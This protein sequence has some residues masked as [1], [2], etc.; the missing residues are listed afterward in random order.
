MRNEYRITRGR[1][2]RLIVKPC[3]GPEKT[4]WR[5]GVL[6]AFLAFVFGVGNVIPVS[7]ALSAMTGVSESLFEE[8]VAQPTQ[9]VVVELTLPEQPNSKINYLNP[10]PSEIGLKALAPSL[11]AA[12]SRSEETGFLSEE[13]IGQTLPEPEEMSKVSLIQP[14]EPETLEPVAPRQMVHEVT[15][16]KGDSLYTIFNALGI[17]Q[18]ELIQLT[19]GDGKQ[20]KRIHPGQSLVFHLA[21]DGTVE[22][23][24]YRID[25]V[26]S[27]HFIRA[28][29]GYEIESVKVAFERR[30]AF[31]QGHIYSSL[32]LAGQT[33]GLPDKTIMEIAEI[34]GWDVDFA[35]DIRTGDR[36]FI[37]YE[38]IYKNEQKVRNGAILA[39]EFINQGRSIRA[40][41]YTDD[42]G[43][44]QYFSPE[45]DSMRKAF[46]RTPV[47]FSRISSRFGKR[48]HP[49]LS[50]VR[51]HNGVDYA[52]RTGTPIKATG[53][54]RTEFAGRKGGYG[55]AVIVRHGNVYTTLYAHMSKFAKGVK[56]GQ[57]VRQGQVIGY[58]G[59]TGLAT[60]PHLHYEFRVRGVHRNP[61]KVE[62][63]KASP[64]ATEYLQDFRDQTRELALQLDNLTSTRIASND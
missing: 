28:E 1:D 13:S 51:N 14:T 37:I 64:I 57:T 40:L 59:R 6:V 7:D 2:G 9:T 16:R 50:T 43:R 17:S 11:S 12:S 38:E 29:T 23:L 5:L 32:F 25:E 47:A 56:T 26:H 39:A 45:G 48:K 62:L 8:N 42:Q 33:A 53:D 63:P 22:R 54:G 4:R 58:V 15:V 34:F 27:T 3:G 61:L 46:L 18:G 36:F 35:L 30:R 10:P 20:L 44:S 52:A 49:V 24:V 41:R 60:G 21:P 19:K 31:A 55:K